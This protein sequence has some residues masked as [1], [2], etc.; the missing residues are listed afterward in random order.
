M[1]ETPPRSAA[2]ARQVRL[3]RSGQQWEFDPLPESVRMHS[4]ISH[5]VGRRAQRLERLAVAEAEAG[6]DVTALELYYDAASAYA[7]AQHTV[8]ALNDEK[9]FLHAGVLRCYDEVRARAPY[10]IER[11]DVP[12]EG[13]T[14]SGYLHLAPVEGPAPLVFF[15]V[16]CDMTKEMAPH[17]L[18]NFA[19]ARGMH[20]FVI[21]GPGQGESNIRGLKLTADNYERAASAAL[22]VLLERPEIDA[23]KVG[24]YSL[25]FGSYWGARFAATDDRIAAAAVVWASICDKYYLFEEE[26]PR[27][28]QLFAFLAGATSE[29]QLDEL[30]EQMDIAQLLPQITCPTLVTVGQYDPRSPLEEVYELF[31]T[32]TAPSELWVFADQHHNCNMLSA[33]ASVW[34]NDHN[35]ATAD[36]LKDRFDGKPIREPGATYFLEVNGVSPYDPKVS[37]K[38]HWFD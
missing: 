8:L 21:D 6:H 1:P 9:R 28:K 3:R 23:S 36:W 5:H 26:S 32:I 35:S 15:I 27:Y 30:S 13:S 10:P 34:V 11:V 22:T 29:E 17:P 18:Y 24:V 20:L 19:H 4:M 7:N 25:S 2:S 37:R 38:R 14:V 33:H 12:F 31:D 16:G